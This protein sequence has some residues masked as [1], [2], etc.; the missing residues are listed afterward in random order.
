[1]PDATRILAGT[2]KGL[3]VL[4][5]NDRRQW[6]TAGPYLAGKE[7]NHATVDPRSGRLLATANDAWFGCQVMWSDNDGED[8]T[9]AT[10]SPSFR[11]TSART[12]ERIWHIAPSLAGPPGRL[13]AGVAPAA[14]FVSDDGGDH[15]SEVEGLSAHP[16]HERWQPGAGGLCL[17]SMVFDGADPDRMWVGISAVGVFE[18]EDGGDSWHTR[19]Q[20]VR[21]GFQPDVFPEFGQCVHKLLGAAGGGGLL[22]QQNHCG[23]Y[24]SADGGR[25]WQ[26]ITEGL[27]SDFGFP[28]GLHP[29]DPDVLYTIPLKGA[30][31][32][33]VPE[34]RLRVFR[35][36]DGGR[37]WLGQT[38]GLPQHDVYC[39]VVREAMDVDRAD[40]AGIYFGTNTGKV[41]ASI[42]EG[43]SFF[44]LADNLPPVYSIT[45]A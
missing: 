24:R 32:R 6:S 36:T 35:S 45:V 1:M 14:L 10:Q 20:G 31:F 41:Y 18:T 44:E 4:S 43:D 25:A 5:S 37:T 11:E 26:E 39:A 29:R 15:W 38:E 30:E 42:D 21:A 7:V 22:Y 27:P 12:L 2:R 23:V 16:S 28:L 9:P 33:C 8:W 40:P 19:N 17:H 13:Y 34:A 3:F